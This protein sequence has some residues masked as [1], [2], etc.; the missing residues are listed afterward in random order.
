MML[1]RKRKYLLVQLECK[2]AAAWL[3]AHTTA[4]ES[5]EKAPFVAFKRGFSS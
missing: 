2:K 3:E 1:F 5:L 4:C